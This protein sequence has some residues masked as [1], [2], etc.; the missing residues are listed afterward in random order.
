MADDEDNKLVTKPFKFV[1]GDCSLPRS[2]YLIDANVHDS[3]LAP[4]TFFIIATIWDKMSCTHCPE[5][6]SDQRFI[7]CL[8]F[9]ARFP[10]QNQWVFN[11]SLHAGT[12][13]MASTELS[14]AGKIMSITTS[15]S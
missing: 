8:G 3:R 13:L 11:Q 10:N 9:D 14:I 12:G 4:S 5:C 6:P 7:P 15:A 1:T 2:S